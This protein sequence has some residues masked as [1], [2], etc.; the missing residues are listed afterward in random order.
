MR[1]RWPVET[2]TSN[3]SGGL[4][5]AAEVDVDR[6]VERAAEDRL[7]DVPAANL[8]APRA[9]DVRVGGHA[10]SPRSRRSRAGG[11]REAWV[12]LTTS[13][14]PATGK[15]DELV[16][17]HVRRVGAGEREHRVAHLLR[18]APGR[19][20]ARRRARESG[21]PPR[22]GRRPRPPPRSKWR[23][24]SVWWSAVACGYGTRI[25]GRAGGRELPDRPARAGDRE[26]GRGERVAEVL[27]LR[28]QDVARPV[29]TT[30]ERVVVPLAA[31][32]A[33]RRGPTRPTRRPPSRSATA[34]RRAPR[35]RRR[36]ARR[37]SRID[38]APVLGARALVRRSG[39]AGRRRE[40][41]CRPARDLVGEEQP[42][43]ERRREAVREARGARRPPSARRGCRGAA[44]RAPSGRRRSPLRR[45]RRRAAVGE[46]SGG[47]GR[48]RPRRAR[49]LAPVPR[50]V[51][52]GGR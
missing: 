50:S 34:P 12:D 18:A 20:A 52:A 23:A 29:D 21:R 15:R 17:D 42:P 46:G 41:S 51:G 9:R 37:R 49:R 22:P 25:G 35:R 40:P 8:R 43:R 19:R 3:P 32:C 44:R 45:G 33:G 1:S 5:L 47:S 11:R 39:S 48:G 7:V 6:A 28:E 14:P 4:G 30:G 31:R 16:G 27:G 24:L 38:V 13:S 36:R 2:I 10:R 26:V